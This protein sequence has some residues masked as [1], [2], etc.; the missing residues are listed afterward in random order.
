MSENKTDLSNPYVLERHGRYFAHNG[1]GVVSRVLLAELYS[2]EYA[3]NYAQNH[4]EV[5]AIPVTALFNGVYEVQQYIERLK[6]MEKA[7]QNSCMLKS[8]DHE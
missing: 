3:E 8:K 7:I 6:I 2:Q 4:H 1:Y 5:K